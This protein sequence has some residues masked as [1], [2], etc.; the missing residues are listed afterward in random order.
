MYISP[1]PTQDLVPPGVLTRITFYVPG[2]LADPLFGHLSRLFNEPK[3]HYQRREVF[4]SSISKPNISWGIP[5]T[6]KVNVASPER[7]LFKY[8]LLRQFSHPGSDFVFL[9]LWPVLKTQYRVQNAHVPSSA[10]PDFFF[11]DPEQA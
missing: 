11:T 4:S 8:S 7:N 5:S 2:L 9:D 3:A 1:E 6:G 10:F